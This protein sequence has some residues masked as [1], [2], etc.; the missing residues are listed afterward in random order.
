[1]ELTRRRSAH[2]RADREE[3]EGGRECGKDRGRG[4]KS[5]ADGGK[6]RVRERGKG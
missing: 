3:V 1:M 2:F 4:R 6:R 5:E